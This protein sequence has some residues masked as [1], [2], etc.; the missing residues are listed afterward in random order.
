MMHGCLHSWEPGTTLRLTHD[1]R[2]GEWFAC[3]VKC[4]RFTEA[5]LTREEARAR[6]EKEWWAI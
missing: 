5:C 2:T 4:R 3:C 1:K 6:A